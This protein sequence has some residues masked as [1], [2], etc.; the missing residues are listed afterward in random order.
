MRL[1]GGKGRTTFKKRG[2]KNHR[3]KLFCLTSRPRL[4]IYL[5]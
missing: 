2:E 5:N 4:S 3:G 1:K